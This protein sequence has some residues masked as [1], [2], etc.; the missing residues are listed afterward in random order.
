MIRDRSGRRWILAWLFSSMAALLPSMTSA[1]ISYT[2][3][4]LSDAVVIDAR[5]QA[6]CQ[7]GSLPGA[8]CLPAASLIGGDG[9]L[10][11]AK[12]LLWRLGTLG[13]S[14]HESVLV[15]GEDAPTRD[16]VAGV[17]HLAGISEVAILVRPLSRLVARTPGRVAGT[18]RTTVFVAPMRDEHLVF[19]REIAQALG[20][21]RTDAVIV[22]GRS[23][24]AFWAGHLPGGQTLP[25]EALRQSLGQDTPSVLAPQQPMIAYGQGPMDGLAFYTLLAATGHAV[26]VYAGG[27]QDW[28]R[29]RRM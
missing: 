16:M 18:F 17:L 20:D 5:P 14:G 13:L 12:V 19:G 25:L 29:L 2:N 9:Q 7:Q 6:A 28:Q 22:D 8:R 15:V 26:R 23:T 24:E 27:W 4:P 21:P 11:G 3:Q 10:I 1:S